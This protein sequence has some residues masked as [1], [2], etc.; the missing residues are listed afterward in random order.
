[1]LFSLLRL[2]VP[3]AWL[4]V[5]VVVGWL[6]GAQTDRKDWK[7]F[8]RGLGVVAQKKCR[9]REDPQSPA[10][11]VGVYDKKSYT[12]PHSHTPLYRSLCRCVLKIMPLCWVLFE[13]KIFL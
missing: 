12:L 8:L 9:M 11:G 13:Y 10:W 4:D 2:D 1:M 3:R 6:A 7:T 5:V